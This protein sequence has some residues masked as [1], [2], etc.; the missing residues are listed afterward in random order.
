M[1][2]S[3]LTSLKSRIAKTERMIDKKK[4]IKAKLDQ[5]AKLKRE[6]ENKRKQYQ[7]M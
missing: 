7:K 3:Q 2:K 4:K 5:V 1:A 6:L